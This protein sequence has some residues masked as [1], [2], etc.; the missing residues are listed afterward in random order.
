MPRRI[1]GPGSR[2]SL[3][4]RRCE[5]SGP[6]AMAPCSHHIFP[7]QQQ[8]QW[9]RLTCPSSKPRG[10][11]LSREPALRT[12]PPAPGIYSSVVRVPSVETERARPGTR[13]GARERA[14]GRRQRHLFWTRARV[15][16]FPGLGTRERGGRDGGFGT[17]EYL[18][19]STAPDVHGLDRELPVEPRARPG[20]GAP[21]ARLSPS[22]IFYLL[23]EDRGSVRGAP[24]PPRPKPASLTSHSRSPAR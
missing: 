9:T 3:P 18:S 2:S 1:S 14:R 22:F 11:R 24:S 6:F 5:K 20:R 21:T 10:A 12:R 16:R 19:G 7:D 15:G 23:K 13:A 4:V 17:R 8:S